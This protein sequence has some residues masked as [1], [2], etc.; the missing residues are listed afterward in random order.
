MSSRIYTDQS[1]CADFGV[2]YWDK[3]AIL[4]IAAN[5][6]LSSKDYDAFHRDLLTPLGSASV[7]LTRT[8]DC[9]P[10]WWTL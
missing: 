4:T 1:Q 8:E 10:G 6:L 2:S 7:T 3:G 9:G 5:T